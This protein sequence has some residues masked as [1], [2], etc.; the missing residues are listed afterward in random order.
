MKI[1]TRFIKIFYKSFLNE[2]ALNKINIFPCLPFRVT[3][4]MRYFN[5]MLITVH[6]RIHSYLQLYN[7]YI[8]TQRLQS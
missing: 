3:K 7:V 6:N 5:K 8:Y 1:I 4:K 2:S